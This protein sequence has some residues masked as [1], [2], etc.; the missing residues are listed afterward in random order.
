MVVNSVTRMTL[1]QG[2]IFKK[3]DLVR[4]YGNLVLAKG[5]GKSIIATRWRYVLAYFCRS[6]NHTLVLRGWVAGTNFLR[7]KR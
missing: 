1:C 4:V 2:Q 5:A 6:R 7:R 3:R